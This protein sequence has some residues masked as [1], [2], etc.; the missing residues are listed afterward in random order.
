M[1]M[2][3][4]KSDII[5]RITADCPLIDHHIVDR[6]IKE[7]LK[8]DYDYFSNT[9]LTSFPDGFDIEIFSVSV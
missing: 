1:A 7:F 4:N 2:R 9:Y 5:L 8:K 6:M 3:E